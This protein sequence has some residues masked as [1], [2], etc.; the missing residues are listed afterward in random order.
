MPAPIHRTRRISHR[1]QGRGAQCLCAL[2]RRAQCVTA[3][4]NKAPNAATKKEYVEKS[5]ASDAASGPRSYSPPTSQRAADRVTSGSG[6]AT[7]P[8]STCPAVRSRQL[9]KFRNQTV[10]PLVTSAPDAS[11]AQRMRASGSR[12]SFRG[13]ALPRAHA[14]F[15]LHAASRLAALYT[16]MA[17]TRLAFA[18]AE[19]VKL[20]C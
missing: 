13:R 11:T 6:R 2:T 12:W 5:S 15:W 16:S 8:A 17:R 9:C 10:L 19:M 4:P 18:I 20:V 1:D 7:R 3:Q 14:L